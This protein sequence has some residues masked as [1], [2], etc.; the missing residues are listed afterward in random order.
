MNKKKIGLIVVGVIVVLGIIGSIFAEKPIE[1]SMTYD[2]EAV[3]K[4]DETGY[5]KELGNGDFVVGEDIEPGLYNITGLGWA[6]LITMTNPFDTVTQNSDGTV[7]NVTLKEGQE[8]S[9]LDQ[10]NSS[11]GMSKNT[12]KAGEKITFVQIAP[13]SIEAA[14]IEEKIVLENDQETCTVDG[15]KED[16]A[17]LK[18]YDELEKQIQ[19]QVTENK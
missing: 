1:A 8:L 3:N 13:K 16:C 6:D 18:N 11:L 4:G 14:T 15:K 5:T 10:E 17:N 12:V 9:V 7:Q 19:A 2:V